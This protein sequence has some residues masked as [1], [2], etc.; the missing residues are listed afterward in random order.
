MTLGQLAEYFRDNGLFFFIGIIGKDASILKY[1]KDLLLIEKNFMTKYGISEDDLKTL[2]LYLKGLTYSQISE[3]LGVSK[4]AIS[5]RLKKT[6][7]K[8]GV[9]DRDK[10]ISKAKNEGIF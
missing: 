7:N 2:R 5:K 3:R 6:R 9:R 8:L 1:D 10:I 4:D